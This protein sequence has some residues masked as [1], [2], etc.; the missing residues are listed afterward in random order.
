[1]GFG[2]T[3]LLI[4]LAIAALLLGTKKLKNLGGDLGE[5]IKSFRGA[6]ADEKNL[7]TDSE[8]KNNYKS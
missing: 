3:E 6:I 7:D 8:Q 1:M 5:G 2:V 4:I